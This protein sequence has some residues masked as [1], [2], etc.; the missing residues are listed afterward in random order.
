MEFIVF[1][2]QNKNWDA[3]LQRSVKMLSGNQIDP[4]DSHLTL[5]K[6]ERAAKMKIKKRFWMDKHQLVTMLHHQNGAI[7]MIWFPPD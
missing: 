4:Q 3:V 6:I 5:I 7:S 1:K 2:T